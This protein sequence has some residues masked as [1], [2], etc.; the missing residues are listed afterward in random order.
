M[1]ERTY[2]SDNVAIRF[3]C[4]VAHCVLEVTDKLSSVDEVRKTVDKAEG[5]TWDSINVPRRSALT[6]AV[7]GSHVVACSKSVELRSLRGK[8]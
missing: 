8:E 4:A 1:I 2:S 3:E 7:P 5:H 6:G